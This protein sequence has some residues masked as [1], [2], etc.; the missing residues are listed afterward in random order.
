MKMRIIVVADSHLGKFWK[1]N[2]SRSNRADKVFRSFVENLE[3][4]GDKNTD[5]IVAGDL[6]DSVHP[7]LEMLLHFKP[8]LEKTFSG[9]RNSF[10]IAGNHETF[11][12]KRGEQQS[13]LD[14]ALFSAEFFSRGV[15]S[16]TIENCNFIFVP[17]QMNMLETMEREIPNNYRKEITNILVAHETP[18][19]IFSYGKMSLAP[20]I[21]F[22][23]KQ[24]IKIPLIILGDYHKP[25][26]I[27]IMDTTIVSV[28]STYYHTIDDVRDQFGGIKKRMLIL[29]DEEESSG[30]CILEIPGLKVYSVDCDLPNIFEVNVENQEEFNSRLEWIL[31]KYNENNMN[32]F[33]LKSPSLINYEKAVY[34]GCDVYYD[35][36]KN[37]E[38]TMEI[39]SEMSEVQI[40]D[41]VS[42]KTLEERWGRYLDASK[43]IS[44]TERQLAEFLFSRRNDLSLDGKEILK[45]M[46]VI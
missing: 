15:S 9:Y 44:D 22:L 45:F 37:P 17:F 38:K 25:R 21:E 6:F 14:L 34:E 42:G 11:V 24:D 23:E 35:Q 7:N 31:E 18:K 26:M 13:I 40:D 29:S 20:L 2:N 33:W 12:N 41:I 5:V 3:R 43:S 10:V 4:M 46:G 28:G 36:I 1:I 32:T 27:K 19:E 30:K 8:I 39:L 16:R